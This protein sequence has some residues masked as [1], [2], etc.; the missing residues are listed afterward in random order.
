MAPSLHSEE[1]ELIALANGLRDAGDGVYQIIPRVMG[2]AAD[3]FA[4]MRRLA[5]ASGRPLSYSL[6][7]MPTGDPDEW[8]V[9]LDGAVGRREATDCRSAP[10][11]RRGRW[12]CSMGSISASTPFLSIPA[13]GRCSTGRWRTRSRRCRDPAFRAQL[14]S[15]RPE[16]SNPV[17]VKTVQAFRYAYPMG[18]APDYEPDLADRIDTRAAALGITGRGACL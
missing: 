15:E 10:R 9:S 7:Q 13:S 12:G 4:L 5:E 1:D 16:D 6:L 17:S 18:A 8:R 14:L 2:P 3:E 11:S